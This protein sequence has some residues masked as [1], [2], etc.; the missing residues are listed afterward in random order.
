MRVDKREVVLPTYVA[1]NAFAVD[2]NE[3]VA[4]AKAIHLHLRAHVILVERKR[5][6]QARENVFDTL[7]CIVAKHLACDDLSLH[8]GVF[9]QVFGASARHHNLL[10]AVRAPDVT[11]RLGGHDKT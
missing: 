11:L 3:D 5:G 8:R 6:H 2:E 9:Q 10:Q 7:A 1:M 4:I